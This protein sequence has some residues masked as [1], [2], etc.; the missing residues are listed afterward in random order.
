MLYI[1]ESILNAYNTSNLPRHLA[2]AT[3]ISLAIP[4]ICFTMIV[5]YKQTRSCFNTDHLLALH[6]NTH[7]SAP[8]QQ[9][10]EI[11]LLL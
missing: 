1:Y 6:A 7:K 10:E 9:A 2:I 3:L 11:H 8:D 4:L 5:K